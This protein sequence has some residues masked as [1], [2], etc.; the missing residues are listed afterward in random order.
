M[1]SYTNLRYYGGLY[2]KFLSNYIFNS[3]VRDDKSF[4]DR[5]NSSSSVNRN[6]SRTAHNSE[7]QSNFVKESFNNFNKLRRMREEIN[8]SKF[9]ITSN[10]T[11]QYDTCT[12]A[13]NELGSLVLNSPVSKLNW[14]KYKAKNANA[15]RMKESPSIPYK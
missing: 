1:C 6:I 12:K 9:G 5:R 11:F 7:F 10:N 8:E 13:V 14:V 4:I 3:K 15:Q 2:I